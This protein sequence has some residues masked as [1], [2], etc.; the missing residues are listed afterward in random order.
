MV[1]KRHSHLHGYNLSLP[2]PCL[3]MSQRTRSTTENFCGLCPAHPSHPT[4][5]PTS[6]ITSCCHPRMTRTWHNL[7]AAS[8]IL[9]D[10][11]VN[12]IPG[13]GFSFPTSPP[14]RFCKGPAID[15][16]FPVVTGEQSW[17]G[18]ALE[19]NLDFNYLNLYQS[20][21]IFILCFPQVTGETLDWCESCGSDYIF[22]EKAGC[23]LHDPPTGRHMLTTHIMNHLSGQCGLGLIGYQTTFCSSFFRTLLF[24]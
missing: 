3:R 4:L 12:S 13:P 5:H 2:W 21:L 10:A 18:E 14:Q 17:G 6:K 9:A 15:H 24:A 11:L 19:I 1:E 20:L 7:W 8:F 22:H 16:V 23:F